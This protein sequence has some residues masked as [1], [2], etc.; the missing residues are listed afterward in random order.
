MEGLR[1]TGKFRHEPISVH[2]SLLEERPQP[3]AFL[4]IRLHFIFSFPMPTHFDVP[5]ELLDLLVLHLAVE[6][7]LAILPLELLDEKGLNVIG[8]LPDV[9]A[10]GSSVGL[11]LQRAGQ[12]LDI[13][14]FLHLVN[15]HLLDLSPETRV[16]VSRDIVLHLQVPVHVPKILSFDLS[17]NR[18]LISFEH[19]G[20]DALRLRRERL[21]VFLAPSK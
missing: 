14:F 17:E 19:V 10:V 16:L 18:S 8:F 4:S 21:R 15:V 12:V 1:G 20:S 11:L 9:L 5:L 3:E 7:H 2:E 13:L 6:L